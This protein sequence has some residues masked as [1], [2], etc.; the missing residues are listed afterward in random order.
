MYRAERERRTVLESSSGNLDS[1]YR[2]LEMTAR[3]GFA[4]SF[5][6]PRI[7]QLTQK[8]NQ[9]NLTTRRYSEAGIR[10]LSE[11]ADALVLWLGLSD[12]FSDN[13]IVGVMIL[14]RL[15]AGEWYIDTLLLSCRVIGRTVENAF[16]GFVARILMDR[17]AEYLIGEYRPTQKNAVTANLYRDLGF[18]P[19][20]EQ[21]GITRWKLSL[22]ERPVAIPEWI[23]IES[24]K[25]V[26]NA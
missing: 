11:A 10:A 21:A 20:G 7:A 8:T 16:V 24:S 23:T 1:Y 19:V 26:L 25:E 4:N 9:F 5:S 22:R 15:S 6:I 14:R 12:R 2:S 17:S 3:V 18:Q 13:G